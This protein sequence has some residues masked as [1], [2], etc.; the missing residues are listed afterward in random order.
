MRLGDGSGRNGIVISYEVKYTP[1]GRSGDTVTLRT[2]NAT[3]LIINGLEQ[4]VVYEVSI[5]AITSQGIG[6]ATV[7]RLPTMGNS[8]DVIKSFVYH[9][10]AV[11]EMLHKASTVLL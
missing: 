4:K 8:C 6:P 7:V 11:K 1:V 2:S 5:A 9:I 10:W 3:M